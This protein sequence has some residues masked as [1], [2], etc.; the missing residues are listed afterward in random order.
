MTVK[1]ITKYLDDLGLEHSTEAAALWANETNRVRNHLQRRLGWSEDA[2]R[3]FVLDVN[4]LGPTALEPIVWFL[5]LC[6]IRA[7]DRMDK[8]E[9]FLEILKPALLITA[10]QTK[11]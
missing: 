2:T 1:T 4:G 8:T 9:K 10:E 3:Q 7:K 11:E 6:E 5:H